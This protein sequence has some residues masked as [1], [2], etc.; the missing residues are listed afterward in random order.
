MKRVQKNLKSLLE[1]KT[2]IALLVKKF[3]KSQDAQVVDHALIG[4]KL[5]SLDEILLGT[6]GCEVVE[7]K[8]DSTD[9]K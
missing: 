7:A 3:L 5:S 8:D 1:M 2:T 4:E 6:P 9:A